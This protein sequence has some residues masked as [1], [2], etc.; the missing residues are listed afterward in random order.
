MYHK[1]VTVKPNKNWQ[2][3]FI[4]SQ[5]RVKTMQPCRLKIDFKTCKPF[6]LD[7]IIIIE[8]TE[9]GFY[10]YQPCSRIDT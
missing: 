7:D 5:I 9:T 8:F 1:H 3:A 4:M 6:L 10:F 2:K